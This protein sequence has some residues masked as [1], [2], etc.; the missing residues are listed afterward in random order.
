MERWATSSSNYCHWSEFLFNCLSRS[1]RSLKIFT[2]VYLHYEIVLSLDVLMNTQF[3]LLRHI[4]TYVYIWFKVDLCHHSISSQVPR[5]NC[6]GRLLFIF[7]THIQFSSDSLP[8][9]KILAH[10]EVI[11]T[12]F[13]LYFVNK[14]I[15]FWRNKN[16]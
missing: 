4:S 10:V 8:T 3:N 6:C 13:P 1:R 12:S 14:S 9:M 16:S 7:I 15:E 2:Y 5:S 11:F